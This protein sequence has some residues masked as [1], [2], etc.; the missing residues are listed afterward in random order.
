MFNKFKVLIITGAVL[1]AMGGSAW[2]ESPLNNPGNP[3]SVLIYI[4]PDVT[5]S[6]SIDTSDVAMDF[7]NVNLDQVIYSTRPSTSLNLTSATITNTGNVTADWWIKMAPMTDTVWKSTSHVSGVTKNTNGSDII[8]MTAILT[9]VTTSSALIDD[10]A[11]DSAEKDILDDQF[12]P[13]G[14]ADFAGGDHSR[15]GFNNGDNVKPQM[16]NIP[17]QD[18]KE[19]SRILW[20]RLKAPS[21]TSVNSR[22]KFRIEIKTMGPDSF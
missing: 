12:R 3:D 18:P 17:G 9:P 19:A 7:G 20:L 16:T 14:P 11:F 13:M 4:I 6:V 21:D 15:A 22:Q 10:G 8:N 2:S 5:Y 1:L